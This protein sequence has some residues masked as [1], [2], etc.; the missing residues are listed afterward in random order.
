MIHMNCKEFEKQIPFYQEDNLSTKELI[1]FMAHM[2]ECSACHEELAIHYLINEGIMH[3]E[4]GS[5]F[6]LQQIM[7]DHKERSRAQLK[8]RKTINRIIYSLEAAIV[9]VIVVFVIIIILN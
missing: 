4:D 3:L 7:N 8:R 9:I 2:G 1:D 5:A 6:D